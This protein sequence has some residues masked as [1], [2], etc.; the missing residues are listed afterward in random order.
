MSFLSARALALSDALR[1]IFRRRWSWSGLLVA[2]SLLLTAGLVLAL[3]AWNLVELAPRLPLAPEAAVFVS[4]PGNDSPALRGKLQ[5]I[6]GVADVRFVGRDAALAA[7]SSPAPATSARASA[8]PASLVA[9]AIADLN[10]NPLPDAYILSF[11][12]GI[13]P[14]VASAAAASARALKGVDSVELDLG[15]YRKLRALL[16]LAQKAAWLLGAVASITTLAWMLLAAS[17]WV[18]VDP[19]EA[20]LLWLAGADDRQIRRRYLYAGALSWAFASA[21]ALVLAATALRW[22]QPSLLSLAS[23]Y[24]DASP[25]VLLPA[26]WTAGAWIAAAGVLGGLSSSLVARFALRRLRLAGAEPWL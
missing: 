8:A 10:G 4:T 23:L 26:P 13:D 25:A 19:V 24:G 3:A 7:L 11:T 22:L 20:R 15:W 14:D 5:R 18:R 2:S 12:P 21:L 1:L 17:V 6:A 16:Q 9:A